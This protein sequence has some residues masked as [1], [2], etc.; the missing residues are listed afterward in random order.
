MS[1]ELVFS[2]GE[3][4]APLTLKV[5]PRA[6]V[7]R[8]RV[9]PRTGAVLLT[10]PRR[11]S[12]RRALEW[13]AGQRQ[14]V[15]TALAAVPAPEPIRPGMTIPLHGRPHLLDWS[16]ER[17]RTVHIAD[18]GRILVGG[19]LEGLEARVLRGLKRHAQAVLERE[20]RAFAAPRGLEV[21]KV[22]VGDTLSRWG[23]C[24]STGTLRYSW[25][26]ILAPDFVRRAT[27]AHE[28]AH[29]VHM[30]HGPDFHALVADLLGADP[31]PARDWLRREGA[32]LHRLFR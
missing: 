10:V 29:L 30:N 6:R 1:S 21:A 31:K 23:S 7:M 12:R 17:P 13:A 28:V 11:V 8:L 9:D 27:V 26:L 14:W 19:P 16:P 3:R 2:A 18:D 22:R 4:R 20:S 25:R 24:S 15:E 32:T 5:S